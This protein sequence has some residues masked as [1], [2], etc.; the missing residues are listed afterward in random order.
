MKPK[1]LLEDKLKLILERQSVSLVL[2]SDNSPRRS[3]VYFVTASPRPDQ[4]AENWIDPLSNQ[5]DGGGFINGGRTFR[6]GG[7]HPL[8]FWASPEIS[9]RKRGSGQDVVYEARL[10]PVFT[11]VYRRR[12]P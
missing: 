11:V 4:D 6:Y 5:R 2:R 7:P 12:E 9:A 10:G 8:T 3:Q 1:R